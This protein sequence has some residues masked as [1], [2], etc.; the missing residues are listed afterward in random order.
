MGCRESTEVL[1]GLKM[2]ISKPMSNGAPTVRDE[3]LGNRKPLIT[4]AREYE[5]FHY[6]SYKLWNAPEGR[7]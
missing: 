2:R 5:P 7:G 6:C 1:L 4:E 3:N